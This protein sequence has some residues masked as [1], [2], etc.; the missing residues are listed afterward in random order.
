M[1]HVPETAGMEHYHDGDDLAVAHPRGSLGFV[2]Q[3]VV[4]DGFLKLDV[5]FVD[6]IENF[7]NFVVS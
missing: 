7:G 3:Q 4:S 5:E 2:S 6:K 1:L